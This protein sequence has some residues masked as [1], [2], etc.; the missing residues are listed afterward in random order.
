MK[1]YL[2]AF[3]L[4]LFAPLKGHMSGVKQAVQLEYLIQHSDAILLVE[5]AIPF[6]KTE[7]FAIGG[8]TPKKMEAIGFRYKVLKIHLDKTKSI[9]LNTK[10]QVFSSRLEFNL[11][12][13][14]FMDDGGPMPIPMVPTYVGKPVDPAKEFRFVIFVRTMKGSRFCM[15]AEDA[16]EK[17]AWTLN[18]TTPK[19]SVP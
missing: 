2:L 14:Q 1:G 11:A 15:T 9:E 8:G 16:F 7:T 4:V 3:A 19:D 17:A 5:K 12:R 10:V 6:E 13:A 18:P